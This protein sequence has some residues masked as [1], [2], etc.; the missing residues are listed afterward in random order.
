MELQQLEV[1]VVEDLMLD[2]VAE[3][4]DLV[5]AE[6]EEVEIMLMEELEL[7]ILVVVEVELDIL[8]IVQELVLDLVDQVLLLLGLDFNKRIKRKKYGILCKN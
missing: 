2:L 7:L 1:E 5:E 4:E 6:Q 3:Q 8:I